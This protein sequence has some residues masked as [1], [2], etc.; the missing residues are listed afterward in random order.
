MALVL[1]RKQGQAIKLDGEA[2]IEI[3][4][5][6]GGAVKVRIIAP[7]HTRILRAE[8][9]DRHASEDSSPEGK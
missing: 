5:I 2:V 4:S 6:S 3:G 1:S 7:D 8:V 9:E